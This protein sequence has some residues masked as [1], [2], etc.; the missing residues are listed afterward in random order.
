L[1]DEE[2]SEFLEDPEENY[3]VTEFLDEIPGEDDPS[4][5]PSGSGM[6]LKIEVMRPKPTGIKFKI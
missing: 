1:D 4:Y 3:G 6:L 5:W 2:L